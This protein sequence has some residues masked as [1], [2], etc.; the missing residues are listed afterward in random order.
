MI[1]A[2]IPFNLLFGLLVGAC[3]TACART[4][5]LGGA[6]PL[7]RTE[8]SM[9]LSFA[10]VTAAPVATYYYVTYP[11]WSWMYLL[12]PSKLARGTGLSVVLF[13]VLM[14][15]VGY[16]SGWLL[17]RWQRE[18]GLFALLG[19]LSMALFLLTALCR[20]RLFSI[21]RYEDFRAGG[22]LL[23]PIIQGKLFFALLCTTPVVLLAAALVGWSLWG[24][25]R[26]LRQQ[27]SASLRTGDH[28]AQRPSRT[29][30]NAKAPRAETEAQT[31]IETPGQP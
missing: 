4:Q 28:A 14:V 3:F 8:L 6:P 5:L 10:V 22:L 2:T 18:R 19:A 31:R 30:Q 21:G 11:D 29:P 20:R 27:A 16:L 9:V 17:L 1:L 26:W 24:Q 25:G 7:R 12:D 15:P 23:R 13:S